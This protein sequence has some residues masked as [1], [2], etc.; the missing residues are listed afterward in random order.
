MDEHEGL[1]GVAAGPK[2]CYPAEDN[3]IKD[4]S[5]RA[6]PE[7]HSSRNKRILHSKDL[8]EM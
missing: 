6:P 4:Q 8:E 2:Q 7:K 3:S 1:V 5:T